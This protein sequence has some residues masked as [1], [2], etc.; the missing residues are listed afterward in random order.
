MN[1]YVMSRGR[2]GKVHTLNSIPTGIGVLASIVCSYGEQAAYEDHY[3]RLVDV[4]EAPATVTNYSQKFQWLLDGGGG[5][6]RKFVIVDDDVWFS[7]RVPGTQKLLK[8]TDG[9]DFVDMWEGVEC[10]L[11]SFPLV[12]V[13]PRQMGHLAKLP[14]VKN[15]KII[16]LQGVNLDLFPG[17]K[18]P[19]VD[20]FPILA[21]VILNCT[22]LSSG[23]PNALLTRYVQD[24]GSCQAPGGCSLY[25]TQAMQEEAVRWVAEQFGPHAKAV[26]KRPKV[27]KWMGDERVD[28]RVQW[29]QMYEAGLAKRFGG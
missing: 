28:L 5:P 7:K 11:D 2:A 18:P 21:D 20:Q 15:G 27:A 14:Y 29:K 17:G 22:L 4:L 1:I 24:H 19:R 3:G 12:G 13:H 26:I 23:Y 16:C 6:A 25:R 10:L 8:I 9:A